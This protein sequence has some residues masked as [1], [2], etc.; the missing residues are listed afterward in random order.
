MGIAIGEGG[1]E[2]FQS[3]RQKPSSLNK[4]GP[5][6]TARY[7]RAWMEPLHDYEMWCRVDGVLVAAT[8]TQCT[9]HRRG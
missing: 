8:T 5:E 2:T 9:L 1:G 4:L 6:L 3:E 7:A